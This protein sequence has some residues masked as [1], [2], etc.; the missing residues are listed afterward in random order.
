MAIELHES[1]NKQDHHVPA[2]NQ[3]SV[4]AIGGTYFKVKDIA[5]IYDLTVKIWSAKQKSQQKNSRTC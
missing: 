2:C 4:D 3:S 1:K 5:Q